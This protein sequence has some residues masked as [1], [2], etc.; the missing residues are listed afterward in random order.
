[1]QNA[2]FDRHFLIIISV[3]LLLKKAIETLEP[4]ANLLVEF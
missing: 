1:M 2:G 4:L 3:L